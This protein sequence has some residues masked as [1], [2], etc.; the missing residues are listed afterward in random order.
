MKIQDFQIPIQIVN[1][2]PKSIEARLILPENI[3]FQTN[4]T[5]FLELNEICEYRIEYHKG[6]TIS[7]IDHLYETMTNHERIVRN[8]IYWLTDFVEKNDLRW[9]VFPSNLLIYIKSIAP[10]CYKPDSS[11][12]KEQLKEEI[13]INSKTEKKYKVCLNP[14]TV[15]EVLSPSTRKY[16]LETKLENY[17]KLESLEQIIFVEQEKVGVYVHEKIGENWFETTYSDLND[18]ILVAECAISVKKLYKNVIF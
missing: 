13:F 10:H 15:F 11:V 1:S 8:F 4:I 17:K 5:D 18:T 12:F 9:E 6:Y 14:N 2:M 16:D 3:A 7:L